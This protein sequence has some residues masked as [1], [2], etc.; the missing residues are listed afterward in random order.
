MS[1][2]HARYTLR[3][4]MNLSK[5]TLLELL[6][7]KDST[8]Y[9]L[10]VGEIGYLNSQQMAYLYTHCALLV[11][12]MDYLKEQLWLSKKNDL[13]LNIETTYIDFIS[14]LFQNEL[15]PLT[16]L[17]DFLIESA[18][19]GMK[20]LITHSK[21]IEGRAIELIK[22]RSSEEQKDFLITSLKQM[23]G[24][25]IT[26]EENQFGRDQDLGHNGLRLYRTFDQIDELFDLNYQMDREMVVDH[27]NPERLYQRAGVGVQSGYSTILLALHYGH[28]KEGARIIDLGSG[29]GRVGLV[30]ALLRPD[31]E[32]IGYEYVPHRVDIS[33]KA[34]YE[35][36]L[37]ERLQ[38]ITQDLSIASFIIPEADVYYLYDPFTE[39]TYHFVLKKIIEISK[40]R[41]IT[42]VTKGNANHWLSKIAKDN[43]WPQGLVIDYGNLCIFKNH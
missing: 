7:P 20:E 28:V 12:V 6:G 8:F 13:S 43:G 34:S 39:E 17:K 25:F 24:Y 21:E 1:G 22:S 42:V 3:S 11:T 10:K 9:K 30:Y 40:K 23:N 31:I 14:P 27:D 18:E 26:E 33:N 2:T 32:F 38:F 15:L 41:N 37:Q 35:L 29:Y 4:S 5:Q 36:G 19:E 16:F